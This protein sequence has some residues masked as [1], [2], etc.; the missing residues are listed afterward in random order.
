MGKLCVG[1]WCVS[2]CVCVLREVLCA[3]SVVQSS[4]GKY[5]VQVL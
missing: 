1:K 4:T 2:V 3:S 5:F